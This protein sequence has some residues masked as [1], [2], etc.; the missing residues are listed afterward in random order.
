MQSP[1]YIFKTKQKK[2]KNPHNFQASQSGILTNQ[3][4]QQN[5]ELKINWPSSHKESQAVET[6]QPCCT[7]RPGCVPT[8]FAVVMHRHGKVLSVGSQLIVQWQYRDLCHQDGTSSRSRCVSNG[9]GQ[10]HLISIREKLL[11][12]A[13]TAPTWLLKNSKNWGPEMT[14]VL[15]TGSNLPG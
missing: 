12:G 4:F 11:E 5:A 10:S 3:L 6:S 7:T 9:F 15:P 1:H 2:P 13:F 8:V 14:V